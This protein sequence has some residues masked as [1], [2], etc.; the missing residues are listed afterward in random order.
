MWGECI[1]LVQAAQKRKF[2]REFPL[3]KTRLLPDSVEMYI[4]VWR[5]HNNHGTPYSVSSFHPTPNMPSLEHTQGSVDKEN[6]LQLEEIEMGDDTYEGVLQKG[7][8]WVQIERDAKQAP[9]DEHSLTIW[10]RV[11]EY[12]KAMF[13]SLVFSLTIITT[14]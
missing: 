7:A 13:W 2:A 9:S 6:V 10:Q 4:S 11:K 1:C 3:L 14:S 12:K 8:N 5:P